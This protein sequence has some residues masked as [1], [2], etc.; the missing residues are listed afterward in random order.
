[1]HSSPFISVFRNFAAA[2]ALA[3]ASILPAMAGGLSDAQI[4]AIYSQV[5]SFD[6]ETAM[7]GELKGN[8]EDVRNIGRQVAHDHTGVRQAAHELAAKIG[9]EPVLPPARIEAARQHD[10][11][12]L[13]LRD[14]DG[15][16]F[17]EAYLV[18]EIGFHQ[19]AINAVETILLPNTESPELKAH[20]E[21][22]LPAFYH[23]LQMNKD[24]AK[25]LGI[26]L[27]KK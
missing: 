12:V 19:A 21:A 26:D 10:T 23:H 8:S 24:A 6:I 5:N 18:H 16:D 15:P 7:L 9:V 2:L 22:V 13:R 1:M 4:L 14:L 20:F 17:D 11:V 25:S 3:A 27:N